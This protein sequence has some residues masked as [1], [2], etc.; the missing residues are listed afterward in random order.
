MMLRIWEMIWPAQGLVN[1]IDYLPAW[2][3]A[4]SAPSSP[5]IARCSASTTEP[6]SLPAAL[7]ACMPAIGKVHLG[8]PSEARC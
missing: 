3:H 1:K 8:G 6:S 5:D 7:L 2:C 4:L